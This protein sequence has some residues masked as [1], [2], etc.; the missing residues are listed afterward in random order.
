MLGCTADA[1]SSIAPC[2][3]HLNRANNK[4]LQGT[5]P[6]ARLNEALLGGFPAL[7]HLDLSNN[8]LS[9][10]I[11]PDWL[12]PWSLKVLD[13]R[14]NNLSGT[15]DPSWGA[16]LPP[17]LEELH[18]EN[19][20]LKGAAAGTFRLDVLRA[21]L[22]GACRGRRPSL[23]EV[24]VVSPQGAACL[25]CM[26]CFWDG[27]CSLMPRGEVVNP[28]HALWRKAAVHCTELPCIAQS[29]SCAVFAS[30]GAN[31]PCLLGI[32]VLQAASPRGTPPRTT[33][34]STFSLATACVAG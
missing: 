3:R 14:L 18:L 7:A 29:A 2:R 8:A 13:L 9:G 34:P 16:G 30:S 1:P 25:H 26:G 6:A 20:N 5:L 22:A 28:G 23:L 32:P 11:P 27:G 21:A 24:P 10:S 31:A 4:V 33:L 12:L 19:N 15:I 17:E